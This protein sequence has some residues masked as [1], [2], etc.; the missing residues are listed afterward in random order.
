MLRQESIQLRAIEKKDLGQ[1]LSWRNK[2][3]MRQFF[4]EYRELNSD[5]QLEWFNKKV[6]GDPN[7]LM[8]AIIDVDNE[9][10][11]G[12]SGL[13]YIDWINRSADF[14]IYIGMDNLYIDSHYAIDAGKCMMKYA[15]EE[16]N[17]H[18]LWCEIYDFDHLK[19]NFLKELGFQI[20]G[21]HRQTHWANGS[22]HDSI[23]YSFLSSDFKS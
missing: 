21:K 15:F 16:L 23:F 19:N 13:C 7:T 14:S 8:F 18:R 1:L 6:I 4:R 11:L 2:P 3:E 10:L 22:W 12:A 5:Q 9:N 20:D 17:L